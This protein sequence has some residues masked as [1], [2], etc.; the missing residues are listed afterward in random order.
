[1]M[2]V[3]S[4]AGKFP[5]AGF[6]VYSATKAFDHFVACGLGVEFEG[7]IDV[8]SYTPGMVDTKLI[9]DEEIKKNKFL[10]IPVER[11]A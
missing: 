4:G 7:K 10:C 3:S 1:M 9:P 5:T 8:M 11:S 2:I 6:S